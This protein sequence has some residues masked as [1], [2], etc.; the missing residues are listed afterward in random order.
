MVYYY[1]TGFCERCYH[2]H[3]IWYGNWHTTGAFQ[4]LLWGSASVHRAFDINN[5]V[6]HCYTFGG[7]GGAITV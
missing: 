4:N 2:V 5:G 6:N 1:A 7:R 3:G